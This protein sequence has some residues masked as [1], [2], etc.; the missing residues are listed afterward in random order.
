[1]T[2]GLAGALAH[3]A[4]MS[5]K[6]G[7]GLLPSFDPYGALQSALAAWTGTAEHPALT[8]AL[9]FISGATVLGLLFGRIY[10]WLPGRSGAAKGLAFGLIGWALM[11]VLLFPAVGLGAFGWAAGLGSA[12][13]LLSLAM[14]LIYGAVVGTVF[15]A[16][17]SRSGEAAKP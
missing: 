11:D 1:M 9:S 4:L 14:V 2:A 17:G 12:P 7:L 16:L 13:A 5:V 6:S 15:A 10:A 8:F 3:T